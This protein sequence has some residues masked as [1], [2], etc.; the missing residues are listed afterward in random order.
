MT[1]SGLRG[2]AST[3]GKEEQGGRRGEH[4]H[5]EIL[6]EDLS[7][8]FVALRRSSLLGGSPYM[9]LTGLYQI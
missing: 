2:E 1:G 6:N 7:K 9:L 3:G 5:N 8:L 4:V